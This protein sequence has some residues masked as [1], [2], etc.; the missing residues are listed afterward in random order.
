MSPEERE[1]LNNGKYSDVRAPMSDIFTPVWEDADAS[2]PITQDD[3][4][5]LGEYIEDDSLDVLFMEKFGASAPPPSPALE[6][7]TMNG[8]VHPFQTQ[9][10]QDNDSTGDE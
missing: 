9:G 4:D 7:K 1:I 8:F 10:G 6:R 5:L 2:S 3:V